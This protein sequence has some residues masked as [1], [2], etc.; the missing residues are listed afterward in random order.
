M[1]LLFVA[2]V[3]CVVFPKIVK[4]ADL[5]ASEA[6]QFLTGQKTLETWSTSRRVTQPRVGYCPEKAT[7]DYG[8]RA[9]EAERLQSEISALA[10]RA[11]ARF[12]DYYGHKC[13]LY[14][15]EPSSNVCEIQPTYG[16]DNI[17]PYDCLPPGQARG[18]SL[19]E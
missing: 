11:C 9:K 17:V 14:N 16:A 7:V 18:E 5:S 15:Y 8:D 13:Y 4:P 10:L 19:P 6:K 2:L 3:G 12:V 1:L